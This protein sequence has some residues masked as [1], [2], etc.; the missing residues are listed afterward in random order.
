ML[1]H[2]DRHSSPPLT[3]DT[4]ARRSDSGPVVAALSLCATLT[5]QGPVESDVGSPGERQDPRIAVVA[6]WS[7][8]IDA[9]V[10]R[11]RLKP[12][13]D[14][15][16]SVWAP[17]E[18]RRAASG[19]VEPVDADARLGPQRAS[20]G[21]LR[22]WRRIH[23]PGL[24]D[25]GGGFIPPD[26]CGAMGPD[27][28]VSTVNSNLS[29]YA[30]ADGRRLVNVGLD[31]F[32][33]Q[34]VGDSRTTY[35]HDAGRFF[36][37]AS[38][39]PNTQRIVLAVSATGDPTGAWF[40]WVIQTDLGSD[41]GAW[42]DFPT[43][44]VDRRGVYTA[45]LMV[46]ANT[47]TLW[48]IDKAPLLAG[49]PQVG[50]ITAWRGLPWEGAVQP[51]IHHDDPGAAYLMSRLGS[52]W[53][54]LRAVRPPLT[55]P[56]LVGVRLY[57]VPHHTRAPNAP[58]LGSNVPLSTGDWR[59]CQPVYRNGSLWIAQT[60][61]VGGR[62]GIR[63]Y[64]FDSSSNRVLQT[65]TLADP[66]W[67]YCYPSLAVD[68]RGDMALGFSG[69]H[70]G[71]YATAFVAA[72]QASDPPGQLGTPVE[73]RAGLGPY[74]RLDGNGTNRF[75]D[76][77][78]TTVDPADDT[79]FW[80]IQEYAGTG[81]NWR[82]VIARAG[83]EACLYGTATP[84]LLGPPEL[85]TLAQPRLGAPLPVTLA[86]STGAPAAGVLAIGLQR[87]S[88]PLLGGTLLVQ[89]VLQ[90]GLTVPVANGFPAILPLPADAALISTPVRLQL[91]QIDAAAPAGI[92]FSRGLEIRANSR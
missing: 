44:G 40:K 36:L 49:T 22:V 28:F 73:L 34:G 9:V 51:C 23:G 71:A 81:N 56:T 26:T 14:V 3:G 75:G 25:A 60:I 7:E 37:A 46:G 76:Y 4:I 30:R 1:Q 91:V 18:V 33:N 77:S 31:S 62:A 78:A 63:W 13:D 32:F 48:A 6:S 59:P 20:D 21:G 83:F 92:A 85:D 19:Q 80:T 52:V 82:T 54:R 68:A 29:V 74:E 79:G 86:S 67:G 43:L 90:V 8:T 87:A 65:G 5:A 89:P 84:G 39:G 69:S 57:P 15:V 12:R 47:I 2:H 70:A 17:R 53:V 58:A 64:E 66:V 42:P 61:D 88:T 38:T 72:R 50:T 45:A 35:D 10:A 16:R 55:A 41:A 11:D 24:G 27:H